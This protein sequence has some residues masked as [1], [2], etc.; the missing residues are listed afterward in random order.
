[1]KIQEP[2]IKVWF[3]LETPK[4][5]AEQTVLHLGLGNLKYF[6]SFQTVKTNFLIYKGHV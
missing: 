6:L 1:M 4:I 3:E 2:S 5:T